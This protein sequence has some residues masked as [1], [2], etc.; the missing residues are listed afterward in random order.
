V[1][2]GA[3]VRAKLPAIADQLERGVRPPQR[4]SFPDRASRPLKLQ[5]QHLQCER[6]E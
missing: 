6:A 2:N 4:R 1:L 3:N 5:L